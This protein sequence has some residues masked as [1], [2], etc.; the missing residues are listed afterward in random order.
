MAVNSS[1]IVSALGAG[2]G[3]DIKDLAQSLVEAERAPFKEKIDARLAK[4]EAKISGYG[5]MRSY[6]EQLKTSFEKLNDASKFGGL[7]VSSS[8]AQ[9]VTATLGTGATSGNHDISVLQLASAQTSRSQGMTS[10]STDLNAGQALTLSLTMQGVSRDITVDVPA[11]L[12]KVAEAINADASLNATGLN[13][14]IVRYSQNGVTYHAL[15]LQGQMGVESGFSVEIKPQSYLDGQQAAVD[16]PKLQERILTEASDARVRVGGQTLTSASNT[17]TDAIPNVTLQL[18]AVSTTPVRVAVSRDVK[19]VRDNI[20]ALVSSFNDLQEALK[21]LADSKSEVETLGGSLVG[22]RLLQSVRSQMRSL[23]RGNDSGN[24]PINALRD[25]G[26]N[27]DLNG[28]LALDKPAKLDA[29]LK[30]NFEG[31]VGLFTS[32]TNSRTGQGLA[33]DAISAINSLASTKS[34]AKGLIQVQIESANKDVTKYK[35]QLKTLE[36]RLQRSLDRYMSQFS[37]MQSLVGESTST[38]SGLKNTFE[39]MASAYR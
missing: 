1:S 32:N 15:E 21:E 37:V 6:L 16:I 19:P 10:A 12:D 11:S 3:I 8:Q 14:Q 29:A 35:D 39:G 2:S 23:V 4:S 33:G 22:D 31:V 36:D 9:A 18:G 7:T 34:Y 28:R 5:A 17:L 20:T 13:A 24:T 27:L 38:R 30:D 26:I 25:L